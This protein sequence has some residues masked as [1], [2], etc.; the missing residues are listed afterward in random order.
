MTSGDLAKIKS[1]YQK[2]PS[3]TA[4][5]TATGNLAQGINAQNTYVQDTK[6]LPQ[7]LDSNVRDLANA[8][9]QAASFIPGELGLM[10]DQYAQPW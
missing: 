2:N 4:C 10:K 8:E 1:F 9:T 5:R 7:G 3:L 6:V